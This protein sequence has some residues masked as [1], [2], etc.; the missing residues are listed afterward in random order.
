MTFRPLQAFP[1]SR[2]AR[3]EFRRFRG[4]LPKIA[5]IFV[6]LVPVLYGAIYLTANWDPYGKLD[7][8][9]VAVVNTD[10]GA[11]F[12]GRQIHAG[13]DFVDSLVAKRTFDWHQVDAAEAERGLRDGDYYLVVDVPSTFSADLIS[14]AGDDP[15][16][17]KISIRRD[18][19][20][21][22]VVGS[23]TNSAQNSIARAV[24]ESAEASYFDAVFANLKLIRSGIS[25][26]AG[27]AGKLADGAAGA[28]D[29]A[30][31]LDTGAASAARGART[32]ATGA[33]EL[34]R[35]LGT[36]RTGAAN[37]ATGLDTLDQ[38]SGDLA[39]GARQVA[40]GTRTLDQTVVPPLKQVQQNLPALRKSAQQAG[41]TLSDVADRAAGRTASVASDLDTASSA[42]A[43]LKRDHPEL[44]DDPN[45]TRVS[46]AVSSASG[47][48]D[49]I[50]TA[51][52]DGAT[53]IDDL[54][55]RLQ[56]KDSLSARITRITDSLDRLDRGAQQVATG[57]GQLHTALG[58]AST[59]ADTL[60]SGI[61]SA[62]TGAHRLSAGA[63]S[64]ST[65]LG[66]LATGTHQLH[67]GLTTL[68][69][70]ADTLHD[71]L[72]AAVDRIPAPTSAEQDR[73]V[74]VLSSPADV[75][76]TIDHPATYYGRGLAP[77]FFSIALW[78]FG[79][80]VF[81]VVRPIT[82]RALAGRIDPLRLALT[83]WLPIGALATV[84]GLLMVGTVW[85]GLGLDPVH[86]WLLLLTVVL[87]SVSFSL[88]AH[89]L[90]TALGTPGSSLLLVLLIL[91]LTSAG[92]TYP[93]PLLPG[94][95]AAVGKVMP[96]TYLIDAF[97]VVIS[98]GQPGHLARDLLVLAA[99]A[100]LAL[101]AC[102]L[103]VRRRKQFRLRDLHPPLIAP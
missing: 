52:R 18:D 43:Q 56:G 39:T 30:A 82:A 77:L 11:T 31:T 84:G 48:A 21:G 57:A 58:T 83:G 93:G 89:L 101:A 2:L 99:V 54:T 61:D 92:G 55:N 15:R 25:D 1:I 4:P 26:A 49:G 78:V 75:T 5:L 28:R 41:A 60:S 16:R 59:G 40:A 14:G 8:L 45:F 29:G 22:F 19:A 81:L 23:I 10:Q 71:K 67:T 96:M 102:A 66:T 80:S 7:R 65:G 100:L 42:L 63:S 35:G 50:A 3:Y 37:L 36:A 88:I 79:I 103:V 64:L 94:F 24:D 33:S 53:T 68:A 17:A 51:T 46:S 87:A 85:L 97:R 70:G 72:A 76:T 12:D 62:A 69:T 32:L 34:D 47:R 6:A 20:N 90:R 86:P 95:F 44:A 27:G 98:G 13:R 9:P 73:A 91:Q 38:R 74:Q